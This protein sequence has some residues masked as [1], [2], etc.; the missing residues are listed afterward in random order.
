[1]KILLDECVPVQVREAFHGHEVHSA[2]VPPWR[3]LGNGELL[4]RA[5]LDGFDLRV[6]ADKNMRFQ[7]DLSVAHLAIL[8]LWTNHRPTL[9]REFAYIRAAAERMESG[10]YLQLKAP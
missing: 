10:Q 3:G 4:I 6:I 1:M 5:G 9:E 8:E 7:Q 2:T